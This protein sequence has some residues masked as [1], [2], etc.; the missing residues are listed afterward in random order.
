MGKFDGILIMSDYDGTLAV[1]QH[2]SE[3]NCAAAE[4]F[5][6]EGGTFCIASGRDRHF[7]AELRHQIPLNGPCVT[8]NGTVICSPDGGT[9]YEEHVF[10]IEAAR[11][12][13]LR[14][15]E[16]CPEANHI[17]HYGSADWHEL[18]AAA[19]ADEFYR[20]LKGPIYKLIT[21]VPSELS[22]EYK[23]RIE[24]L[25]GDGYI[26]ARSWIRG[27]EIQPAGTGKGDAIEKLKEL[28]GGKIHTVI[29]MGDFENDIGML[30]AADVGYA[31]G[32]ATDAVKT[33]AD[34][35]TVPASDHALAAVVRELDT[36][37]NGI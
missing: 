10:P 7:V 33:A 19:Q 11:E 35:I 36:E 18:E 3:E 34:R 31:V 30:K 8:L 12:I 22:D 15:L 9:V 23:S 28:S 20:G 14:V 17:R 5:E 32:N 29:A 25:C 1:H 16:A 13:A 27:I 26:I 2:I 4:Y 21:V 6:R 24:A 37:L